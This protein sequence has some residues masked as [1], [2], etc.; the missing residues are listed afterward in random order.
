MISVIMTGHIT[1]I[2]MVN[3]GF[4]VKNRKIQIKVQAGLANMHLFKSYRKT[5]S[6]YE[7]MIIYF[8]LWPKQ[9][10]GT[11]ELIFMFLELVE[12]RNGKS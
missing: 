4:I 2:N 1:V 8:V 3:I 9:I 10:H 7:I 5:K 11:S 12:P 6:S